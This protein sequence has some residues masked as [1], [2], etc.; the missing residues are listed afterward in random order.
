[1]AG[2]APLL[3]LAGISKRFGKVQANSEVSLTLAEG[4]EN[5]SFPARER[6]A[7]SIDIGSGR[8]LIIHNR[9]SFLSCFV[10]R[11]PINILVFQ[12]LFLLFFPFQWHIRL[13][14]SQ[15]SLFGP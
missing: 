8:P 12:F 9:W 4:K 1:M 13:S 3:R 5:R 10:I 11:Q 7:F 2:D 14:K 6:K 15:S